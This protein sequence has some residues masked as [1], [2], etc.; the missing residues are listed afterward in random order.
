MGHL[1]KR[2]NVMLNELSVVNA[3][4]RAYR[5]EY[6]RVAIAYSHTP[7]DTI[8]LRNQEQAFDVARNEFMHH[9]ISHGNICAVAREYLNDRR[10]KVFVSCGT[11]THAHTDHTVYIVG[12][13]YYDVE[14]QGYEV[15]SSSM[16]N[17]IVKYYAIP[18]VTVT[19]GCFTNRDA[20]YAKHVYNC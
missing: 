9:G 14:T 17:G 16:Q 6:T 2:G 7:F 1:M 19:K 20:L 11:L 5:E 4:I 10:Y 18:K 3:L 8:D 12:G 13:K 15:V